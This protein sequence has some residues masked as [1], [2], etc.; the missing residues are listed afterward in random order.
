MTGALVGGLVLI[1]LLGLSHGMIF[2]ALLSIV[3]GIIFFFRHL[4][5]PSH[6]SLP[7]VRFLPSALSLPYFFCRKS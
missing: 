4:T 2:L 6:P 3:V 1:P 5:A 7:Q